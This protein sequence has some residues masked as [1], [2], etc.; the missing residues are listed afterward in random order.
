MED[1]PFDDP[2]GDMPVVHVGTPKK[3]VG[4][5]FIKNGWNLIGAII[6]AA[7]VIAAFMALT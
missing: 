3:K 7:G 1:L 6:G 2:R 5:W 4:V